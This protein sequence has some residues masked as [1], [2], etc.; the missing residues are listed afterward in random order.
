MFLQFLFKPV[1]DALSCWIQSGYT[2][3]QP[4]LGLI[5]RLRR[6]MLRRC[7]T[8]LQGQYVKHLN[9]IAQGLTETSLAPSISLQSSP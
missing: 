3:Y 7:T 4:V 6:D 8:G 9:S 1:D 5:D 2:D